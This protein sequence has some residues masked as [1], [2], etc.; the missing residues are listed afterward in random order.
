MVDGPL[1]TGHSPVD[2]TNIQLLFA[3]NRIRVER[4]ERAHTLSSLV[5]DCGGGLGLFIGFNFLMVW[6]WILMLWKGVAAAASLQSGGIA[7]GC[8]F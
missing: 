1:N 5:S 7:V 6:D 4:E 8:F 2:E 3:S